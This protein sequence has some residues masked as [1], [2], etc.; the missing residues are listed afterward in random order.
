MFWY[1]IESSVKL[2]NVFFTLKPKKSSTSV[3]A[4]LTDE[5]LK[6]GWAPADIEYPFVFIHQTLFMYDVTMC[7]VT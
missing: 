4:G 6:A 5:Q 7:T 2:K 1:R 3:T